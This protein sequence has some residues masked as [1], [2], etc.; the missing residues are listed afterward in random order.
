MQ[1]FEQAEALI[2]LYR[3]EGCTRS[4]SLPTRA[5]AGALGGAAAQSA[6]AEG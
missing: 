1:V 2:M 4:L 5:V 6:C 3:S